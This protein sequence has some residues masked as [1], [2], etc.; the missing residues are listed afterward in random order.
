[1]SRSDSSTR[2]FDS[3]ALTT[4]ASVAKAPCS[5]HTITAHAKISQQNRRGFIMMSTQKS[6][7]TDREPLAA[8]QHLMRLAQSIGRFRRTGQATRC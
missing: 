3:G 5:T 7:P 2:R 1:M 4:T 8:L 6:F